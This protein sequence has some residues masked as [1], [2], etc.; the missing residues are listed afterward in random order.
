MNF[1]FDSSDALL[2]VAALFALG[3][4]A[5]CLLS[6]LTYLLSGPAERAGRIRIPVMTL[7]MTALLSVAVI[8]Q[9][10]PTQAK[11]ELER[12]NRQTLQPALVMLREGPKT[13]R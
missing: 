1:I 3:L 9:M 6:V 10:D 7:I 11:Q 8:Y 2:Y 12:F 5:L 13:A 4:S